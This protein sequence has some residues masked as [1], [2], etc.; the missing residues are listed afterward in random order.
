M[1]PDIFQAA[2]GWE[3]CHL[4]HF[5]AGDRRPAI[6]YTRPM[7]PDSGMTAAKNV[8]LTAVVD[9]GARKLVYT[10]DV[11]D[12]W[13]HAII[14]EMAGPGE[15]D[16]KFPRFVEGQRHCPP[17]DVGGLPS[18]EPFLDAIANP[19]YEELDRLCDCKSPS[20]AACPFP[21]G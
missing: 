12:D 4:W 20:S 21:P 16:V 2:M 1:L 11:G 10:Y 14:V 13:R 15:P 18:F 5:E 9:Q 19:A 8:K 6:R 3:N 7:W 17:E